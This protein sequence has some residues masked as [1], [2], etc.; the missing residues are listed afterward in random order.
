MYTFLF[1]VLTHSNPIAFKKIHKYIYLGV[2]NRVCLFEKLYFSVQKYIKEWSE[3]T[4]IFCGT[5]GQ[6]CY[7][8][9]TEMITT[10]IVPR[11]WSKFWLWKTWPL[12]QSQSLIWPQQQN[13]SL[14]GLEHCTSNLNVHT[15]PLGVLLKC[16][17]WLSGTMERGGEEAWYPRWDQCLLVCKQQGVRQ[18]SRWNPAPQR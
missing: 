7:P 9:N 11:D 15:A 1:L 14:Y 5:F 4:M 18:Y 17:F 12:T 10:R 2:L 16:R 13:L 3:I 6:N 8:R